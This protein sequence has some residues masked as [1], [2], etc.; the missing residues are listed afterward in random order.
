[1]TGARLARH[2]PSHIEPVIRARM[3]DEPVIGSRGPRAAGKTMLL[4]ALAATPG[5][6]V[7][8]LDH[9]AMRAAVE[10]DRATFVSGPRPV[11]I[12]EH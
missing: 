9:P 4:R 1:M 10:M 7:L 11:F 3:L 5:A 12:D 2:V 8:D 6:S